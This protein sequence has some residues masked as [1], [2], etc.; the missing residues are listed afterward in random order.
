MM[1]ASLHVSVQSLPTLQLWLQPSAQPNVQAPLSQLWLQSSPLQV[2]SH[3]APA[4][5]SC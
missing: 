5:Q 4:S 1:Q 3:V 2:T